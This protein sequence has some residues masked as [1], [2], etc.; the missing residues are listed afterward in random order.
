MSHQR[1][2]L[3]FIQQWHSSSYFTVLILTVNN[4]KLTKGTVLLHSLA[5][6]ILVK[7]CCS[8]PGFA[9]K[10]TTNVNQN[11]HA[12]LTGRKWKN[13]CSIGILLAQYR[14]ARCECAF[15]FRYF[16]NVEIKLHNFWPMKSGLAKF[17]QPQHCSL[18]KPIKFDFPMNITCVQ[19]ALQYFYY[20]VKRFCVDYS[21]G[22]PNS[23]SSSEILGLQNS[24]QLWGP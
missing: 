5:P 9:A 24:F 15:A 1:T 22:S 23:H 18:A 7:Q 20:I 4:K 21:R 10:E 19:H 2:I 16:F 6:Q 14:F 13:S 3:H 8:Y 17:C 12:S 11:T